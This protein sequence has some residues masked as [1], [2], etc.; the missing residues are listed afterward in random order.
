MQASAVAA[1]NCKVDDAA[2]VRTLAVRGEWLMVAVE[3]P[4]ATQIADNGSQE[5]ARPG[6]VLEEPED[7]SVVLIQNPAAPQVLD[8]WRAEEHA[9]VSPQE[10]RF[11]VEEPEEFA[12]VLAAGSR[13]PRVAG[14]ADPGEVRV[15]EVEET[16]IEKHIIPESLKK[17]EVQA[18]MPAPEADVS[19][20]GPELSATNTGAGDVIDRNCVSGAGGS[21]GAESKSKTSAK[22]D[23]PTSQEK[24]RGSKREKGKPATAKKGGQVG[25][26]WQLNGLALPENAVEVLLAG[27]KTCQSAEKTQTGGMKKAG[28]TLNVSKNPLY[29]ADVCPSPGG[30]APSLAS[31]PVESPRLTPPTTVFFV[32]H[33]AA[34]PLETRAHK[35]ADAQTGK[36]QKSGQKAKRRSGAEKKEVMLL[37]KPKAKSEPGGR[38][39]HVAV[40]GWWDSVVCERTAAVVVVAWVIALIVAVLAYLERERSGAAGKPAPT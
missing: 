40:P 24:L 32:A 22:S 16:E 14:A 25:P 3:E 34:A 33:K 10:A 35:T 21:D 27:G 28:L 7:A 11:F 19:N 29:D 26:D 2:K 5:N 8:L 20:V 1:P 36:V 9:P 18:I 12:L 38:G 6:E 17:R 4:S 39:L 13:S 30:N 15:V 31:V 23:K 37:E